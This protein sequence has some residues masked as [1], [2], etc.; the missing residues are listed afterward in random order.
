M[1]KAYV[2][3]T[4]DHLLQSGTKTEEE[5]FENLHVNS[6]LKKKMYT[7]VFALRVGGAP[8]SIFLGLGFKTLADSYV[9]AKQAIVKLG[10]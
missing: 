1:Y 10:F 6:Y 9:V 8:E 5:S 2:L 3:K 4:L 7:Q